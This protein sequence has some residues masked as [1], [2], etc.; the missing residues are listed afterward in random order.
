MEEII[1]I[2][3]DGSKQKFNRAKIEEAVLA[4]TKQVLE[5]GED[6]RTKEEMEK[7]SKERSLRVR[8]KNNPQYGKPGF[9]TGRKFSASHKEKISNGLKNY[10]RTPEHCKNLQKQIEKACGRKVK[11]ILSDKELFFNSIQSAPKETGI[12]YTAIYDTLNRKNNYSPKYDF[13]AFYIDK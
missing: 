12:P 11:V 3:K 1:V 7:I 6:D 13:Y 4:A 8:G 9:N 2:K 10:K 5:I